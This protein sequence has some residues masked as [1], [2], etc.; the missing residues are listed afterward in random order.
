MMNRLFVGSLV[1][2]CLSA[3]MPYPCQAQEI[4]ACYSRSDGTLRIVPP[5][6]SCRK[7]EAALSWNKEGPAGPP[8]DGGQ[9]RTYIVNCGY[10]DSVTAALAKAALYAGPAEIVI[11]GMCHEAV[12][13]TRSNTTLRGGTPGSGLNPGSGVALE[14]GGAWGIS[15]SDLTLTGAAAGMWISTAQVSLYSSRIVGNT[16]PGIY[17]ENSTLYLGP[18]NILDRNGR[19]IMVRASTLRT[20]GAS[21]TNNLGDGITVM[22][23]SS[24]SIRASRIAR[25]TQGGVNM[26]FSSF[27][28][29]SGA[30]VIELNGG[31]IGAMG[32]STMVLGDGVV[33]QDN[34]G[35][36]ISLADV[37]VAAAFGSP[38]IQN[39]GGVGVVCAGSPAAAQLATST[40]GT[41]INNPLGN[42]ECPMPR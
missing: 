30:T 24:A 26:Y 11:N 39:N 17:A 7:N 3:V 25:N 5:L 35:N 16:E 19:G 8:G 38:L 32:G 1:T 42:I 22:E 10:G 33:I 20:D 12:I 37:S 2:L 13:L 18:G 21:I 6:T 14:V 31:G 36:G 4:Y 27:L 9:T 41:V 34:V 23:G 29:L 40:F 28:G 15:V